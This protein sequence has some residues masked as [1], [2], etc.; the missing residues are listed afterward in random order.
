ML[1]STNMIFRETVLLNSTVVARHY[2]V[3]RMSIINTHTIT[4]IQIV[5]NGHAPYSVM[6]GNST[7]ASATV[8]PWK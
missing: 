6:P 2:M 8:S 7:F 1:R 5:H 4:F 3:W